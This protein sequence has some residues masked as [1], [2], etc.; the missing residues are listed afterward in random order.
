MDKSIPLAHRI[1]MLATFDFVVIR[2]S[3]FQRYIDAVKEYCVDFVESGHLSEQ[4]AFI[5]TLEFNHDVI[6]VCWNQTS[7]SA[8]LW[9]V[10]I[11]DGDDSRHYDINTD[12]GHWYLFDEI[13]KYD[14]SAE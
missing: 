10:E 7:V 11:E 12:S 13:D 3:E 8:P 6:G 9:Y 4:A 2:K 1:V 14:N 5:A